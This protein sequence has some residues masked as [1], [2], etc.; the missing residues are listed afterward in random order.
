LKSAAVAA[1]ASPHPALPVPATALT[2]QPL[3]VVEGVT[4]AEAEGV[5][6][7]VALAVMEGEAPCESVGVGVGVRVG[8][9][10]TAHHSATEPEGPALEGAPPG[11][12]GL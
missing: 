10:Y 12:P 3:G 2:L 11:S 4:V 7:G 8:V 9:K 5:E 6:E 1:A